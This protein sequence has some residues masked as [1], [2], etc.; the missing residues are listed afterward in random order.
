[1][2]LALVTSGSKLDFNFDK[3]DNDGKNNGNS[4]APCNGKEI[5][6]KVGAHET[7]EAQKNEDNSDISKSAD[8]SP[9]VVP[10]EEPRRPDPVHEVCPDLQV[11]I[12]DLGN[13]CWVVSKADQK[14]LLFMVQK[15]FIFERFSGSSLH[16][17]HPNTA[18]S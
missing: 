17:G 7:E 14:E 8:N 10:K 6:G 16:R 4:P 15:Y 12:A 3:A 11:K 18:I 13:A 2:K 5:A 9:R 1:M